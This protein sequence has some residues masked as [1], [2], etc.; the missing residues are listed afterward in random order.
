MK[1]IAH[2]QLTDVQPKPVHSPPLIPYHLCQV[3]VP[4][5]LNTFSLTPPS[6]VNC[7]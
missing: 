2:H 5:Y 7:M 3:R 1:T 4:P 6:P